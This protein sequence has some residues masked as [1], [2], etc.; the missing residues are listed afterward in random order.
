MSYQEQGF[1]SSGH[2]VNAEPQGLEGVSSSLPLPLAV[3][4]PARTLLVVYIG[5]SITYG[6]YL[7]G[8]GTAEGATPPYWCDRFLS[9]MGGVQ[10]VYG[11]NIG[12][13][14]FT[15]KDWLPGWRGSCFADAETAAKRL[16]ADHPE[17]QIVF[18]IMLGTNDSATQGPNGSPVSDEGYSSNLEATITRLL[19]DFP[20][21]KVVL[22]DAP[23]YSPNTHNGADYQEAGLAR[24]TGYQRDTEQVVSYF[25][26]SRRGRVYL[27]DTQAYA[28]FLSHYLT[29]LKEESTNNGATNGA[30]Y[31]HPNA[32]GAEDLGHLWAIGIERALDSPNRRRP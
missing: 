12:R 23:Y 27:G 32:A 31:L 4:T 10:A 13:A 5:D 30:F 20:G 11:A 8:A 22:N 14:G 24:L 28:F 21:C 16:A 2:S 6:A 29:E 9:G 18:P 3:A 17:G 26:K 19:A 1:D 7:D 25:G 15:T